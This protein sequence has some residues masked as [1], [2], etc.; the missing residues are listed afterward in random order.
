MNSIRNMLFELL[1]EDPTLQALATG[2]V[3]FG[4]ADEDTEGPYVIFSQAGGAI[5]YAM[6]SELYWDQ[7]WDVKGVGPSKV[8]GEIDERCR[9]LLTDATPAVAGRKVL[10]LRP[11]IDIN[12]R[13]QVDSQFYQHVGATY[14]II[15]EKEGS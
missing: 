1:K 3:W 6:Q 9:A 7:Q 4:S 2:G 13:E 5:D 15:T 12:Y 8:A 10:F 11:L 14:N